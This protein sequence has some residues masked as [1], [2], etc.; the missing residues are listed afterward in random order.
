MLGVLVGFAVVLVVILVGY[1]V[2]RLQLL[3][4]HADHVLSRVAF[5]VLSP[6]LLFTVLA[7]A[8]PH[9]LFSTQ[10]PITAV[11]CVVSIALYATVAV[12]V[13]RRDAP[14]TTIGALTV[15]YANAGNIGIPLSVY[16]L[17]DP[18]ASVPVLLFQLVVLAPLSLTILDLTTTGRLSL[19][20]ILTQPIRNPLIIG[21]LAGLA[22]A[23][24][25]WEV[26]DEI[27]RPFEL[28]GGAAIPVVLLNFGLSLSLS[29][30]L[31]AGSPRG[32]VVFAT[33]VKLV[34]APLIAWAMGRFVFGLTEHALF[35]AT[36]LAGLP[37]AQNIYNYARRYERAIVHARDTIFVTTIASIGTVTLIAAVLSGV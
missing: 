26:P 10:L 3:G 15:S 29:R 21:S 8:D 17:G 1:V 12:V 34:V 14:T 18:A 23:M 33:V 35:V 32:E 25:E 4:D 19:G 28:I 30:P 20:R 9:V 7:G 31:G 37:T 16:V 22:I 24:F 6:C 13:W 27:M 5:F 36:V 2:G 11:S